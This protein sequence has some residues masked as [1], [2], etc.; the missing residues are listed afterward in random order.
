MYA[1]IYVCISIVQFCGFSLELENEFKDFSCTQT[2]FQMPLRVLD[3][4]F[5]GGQLQVVRVECRKPEK[6]PERGLDGADS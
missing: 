5:R 3:W 1:F 4:H 2:Y 6:A